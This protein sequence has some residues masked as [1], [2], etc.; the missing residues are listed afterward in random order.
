MEVVNE[1]VL[2]IVA[3]TENYRIIISDKYADR[4]KNEMVWYRGRSALENRE[5]GFKW[6]LPTTAS[7]R[8]RYFK[9]P[10]F[11]YF[12]R[13]QSMIGLGSE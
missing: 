11:Y 5:G 2:M 12:E 6:W 1:S 8:R 9:F 13:L 7:G 4:N 10:N 3:P